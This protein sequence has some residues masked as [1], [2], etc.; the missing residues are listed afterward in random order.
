VF[1]GGGLGFFGLVW[2][3]LCVGDVCGVCCGWFGGWVGGVVFFFVGGVGGFGNWCATFREKRAAEIAQALCGEHTGDVIEAIRDHSVLKLADR[4]ALPWAETRRYRGMSSRNG[5][6]KSAGLTVCRRAAN[7]EKK[8]FLPPNLRN[9]G[10][11][12]SGY[13]FN[14]T[15]DEA[16]IRAQEVE[17]RSRGTGF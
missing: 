3:C 15:R 12:A 5:G 9:I 2:C 11:N 10:L 6:T 1:L 13:S 16:L 4:P 14:K 17:E 7:R 8:R